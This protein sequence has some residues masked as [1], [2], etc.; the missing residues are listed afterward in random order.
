MGPLQPDLYPGKPGLHPH[1]SVHHN[2][3]LPPKE[4]SAKKP[5]VLDVRKRP[6]GSPE[7]SVHPCQFCPNSGCKGPRATTV[8]KSPRELPQGTTVVSSTKRDLRSADRL[9]LPQGMGSQMRVVVFCCLLFVGLCF[10]WFVVCL[11]VVCLFL[12]LILS[13]WL[14]DLLC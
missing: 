11:F 3:L 9:W 14:F 2:R 10:C 13:L 6:T 1:I 12:G 4:L 5:E 8:T 7:F